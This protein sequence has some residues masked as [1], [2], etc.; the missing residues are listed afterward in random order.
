MALGLATVVL[1]LIFRGTILVD[2]RFVRLRTLSWIWSIENL[3]LALA[4]FN[5]L[6][7][8]IGFN[9]MTRMRVVGL[10]GVASVVAGF[11]LVL[12]KIARNHDFTWL[13]RRQLWAVSFAIFLYAILPVDAFVNR[14][15]V[16]CIL[17]GNSAP[18]VQISVHPTS[19]EGFLF[20]LPLVNCS[21]EIVRDGVRAML[22]DQLDRLEADAEKNQSLGWTTSQVAT[23]RLLEQLKSNQA[24]WSN[25][26]SRSKREECRKKFNDYAFQ[27]Y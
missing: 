18:S 23:R 25:V 27:W 21:D 6:F 17:T 2:P 19:D 7:I 12:Q 22:A 4:V 10:L 5:R 14:F 8:Y 11:L 1:S 15:N 16:D 26:Q 13:I 9:G 20:L 24:D 3:L